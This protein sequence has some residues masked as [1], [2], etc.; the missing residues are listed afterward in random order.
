MSDAGKAPKATTGGAYPK[1]RRAARLAAIQALYQMELADE[2]SKRVI[3]QFLDHRFSQGSDHQVDHHSGHDSGHDSGTSKPRVDKK[4]FEDIAHG[5]VSFQ[6]DIDILIA[7]NLPKTWPLRRLHATLRALLRVASYELL[8]RPDIP[9]L[10]II[11]EYVGL[12]GQFFDGKEPA[13]VNGVLDSVAKSVR[14]VE[15]GIIGTAL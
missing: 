6:S 4:F 13:M 12:S 15:F 1:R 11:S 3:R 8:R 2:P 14:A 10:V 9:A 7:D 5:T